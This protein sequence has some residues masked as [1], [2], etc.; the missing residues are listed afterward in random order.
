MPCSKAGTIYNWKRKGVIYD[1]YDELYEVYIK[2]MQ[3]GHCK[4]EFTKNNCRCL[5]HDHT[6]GLFRKIVC[7]R[8]NTCDSYINYPLG[9]TKKEYY[10]A[11]KDKLKE[12]IKE[13]R[14]ANKDKI[15]EQK[16]EYYQENKEKFKEQKK[17]YYQA[18]KQKILAYNKEKIECECGSIVSRRYIA[19][20]N[21]TKKHSD[22]KL[23]NL[24]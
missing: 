19:Q 6:T 14:Q 17:E 20:H 12:Q 4:T 10:Q 1:N 8:C 3:C 7:N 15:K 21:R 13:Y 24:V 16:K 9:Y 22:Y 23:N 2:T 18:N 5:D 11:N